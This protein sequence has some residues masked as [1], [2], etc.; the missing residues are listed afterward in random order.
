M[1]VLLRDIYRAHH[2]DGLA[3]HVWLHGSCIL[4]VNVTAGTFAYAAARQ[5]APA[6]AALLLD[7]VFLLNVARGRARMDYHSDTADTAGCGSDAA[8]VFCNR[9]QH[10]L[11]SRA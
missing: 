2:P 5:I 4:G 3:G 6:A 8:S 7:R 11:H 9:S 1:L 10:A